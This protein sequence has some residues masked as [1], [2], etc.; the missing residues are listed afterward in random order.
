MD[1][2][3]NPLRLRNKTARE[4]LVRGILH[5][6]EKSKKDCLYG[7]RNEK[8]LNVFYLRIHVKKTK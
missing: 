7:V 1:K 2:I 3:H 8:E 4:A 6:F 5:L